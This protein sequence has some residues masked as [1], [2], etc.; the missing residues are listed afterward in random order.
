MAKQNWEPNFRILLD[1]LWNFESV[2]KSR[3][4]SLIDD[5]RNSHLG[6]HP[7]FHS[8]SIRPAAAAAAAGAA[9]R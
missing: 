8:F 2:D 7:Q 3:R 9:G 1:V 6:R 5:W 4:R